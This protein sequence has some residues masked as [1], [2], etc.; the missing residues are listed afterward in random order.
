MS[1]IWM[2]RR[3][4]GALA[5][6]LLGTTA[7]A[8]RAEQGAPWVQVEAGPLDRALADYAAQTGEQL[9]YPPELTAGRRTSGLSGRFEAEEGVRRLLGPAGPVDVVRAGPGVLVLKASTTARVPEAQSRPFG[10]PAGVEPQERTGA[11]SGQSATVSELV[12]TGSHIRG[13]GSG[14]SPVIVLGADDLE[15]LGRATVAEALNLLPQVFGGQSTEA[16]AALRTDRLGTNVA[17]G[18]SVNLRGLGSDATLVLVNGRRLA[19]AGLR[20]DFADLSTLPMAAVE[21]IE[22]LLDGASAIYGSDAVGGVV[23][24]VLKSDYEGAEAR[25]R[26]GAAAGGRPAEALAAGVIGRRWDGGG[27]VLSYEAYRRTALSAEDRPWTASADLRPLGGSD[28]RS[29]FAYP[30]NILRMDPATGTNTPYWGIPAGAGVGLRPTDFAAGVLNL[31]DPRKRTD[32][33]P[34]QRR[35]SVFAAARQEL[36]ERL[37]LSGDLRYGQ[38]RARARVRIADTLVGVTR[39]NPFFV[40]PSGAAVHQIAFSFADL[41]PV[42]ITHATSESLSASVGGTFRLGGDWRADGYLGLAQEIAENRTGGMLNSSLLNETLGLLPDRPETGYSAARD[43]YFNPFAGDRS[44]SPAALAAIGSGFTSQRFRSRVETANLQADGSLL[45]LPGG[46]FKMA[47]GAQIRREG[48]VRRGTNFTATSLPVPQAPT[49]AD[50]EV[51]AAFAELRA[52]VVGPANRRVGLELLEFSAAV[53]AERYSDFGET[54][55][56]KFGVLWSPLDGLRLR[57]TYG[58]SFRAPALPEVRDAPLNSPGLFPVGSAR[59]LGLIMSGGNPALRPE[60]AESWT[61]GLDWRPAALPGLRVAAT[62]FETRFEDRIDQPVRQNLPAALTDPKM[63]SFVRRITPG[64]NAADLALIQQ[65]LSD[66]ATST[67][68]GSFPAESYGAIVD[69]RYVNTGRLLVRGFDLQAEHAV[70]LFGGRLAL[71]WNGTVLTRYDQ[72]LTPTAPTVRLLARPAQPARVRARLSADWT[73]G[74]W[75]F[76]AAANHASGARTDVGRDISGQT[77]LDAS[78][79]AD[80][81]GGAAVTLSVRNLFDAAP[82]FYD[83]PGGFGFDPANADVVGRFV[84]LQLTRKW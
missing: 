15:R 53:R 31:A 58:R 63:A 37:E 78:V 46:P 43:G 84:T 45:Q 82:P 29:P 24:V 38:R 68:Q 67:A 34:D 3:R 71:G 65:L 16:T 25:L 1:E 17:Y 13:G 76:G 12:I 2:E 8:C 51:S 27:L 61:A 48:L 7:G 42:P 5:L 55:N 35:H 9:L 4:A 69:A 11:P 47:V 19:G 23:N 41:L 20:G 30:G 74:G 77:T 33:L 21:R 18:A 44:A 32:V 80:L 60:T 72:T 26:V 75:A 40:S 70:G 57:A 22:V 14:A 10:V 73:R 39:A 64:S 79:R 54:V 81:P 6:A 62:A 66:P 59:V 83:N 49:D 56:P 28:W 36:G 52:P 50:R